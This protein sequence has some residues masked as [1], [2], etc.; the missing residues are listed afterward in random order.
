ALT[1]GRVDDR[2]NIAEFMVATDRSSGAIDLFD[3]SA[4]ASSRVSVAEP[5]PAAAA[6]T[7]LTG[8][9]RGPTG[10]PLPDVEL[11][12]L[13]DDR[14]VRTDSSG[15]YR[16]PVRTSAPTV[17]LA[18]AM[19]YAAAYHTVVPDRDSTTAWSP[20]LR[21]VQQ[22]AARLVKASGLPI[23]LASWR[24]DDFM[25]RRARGIGKFLLADEIW[26]STSIGDALN[27]VPGV[28]VRMGLAN[29]MRSVSVLRCNNGPYAGRGRVGVYVDG[30][31]RTSL[32]TLASASVRSDNIDPAAAILSEFVVADVIGIEIYRGI[33][34]IPAD[35]ANPAYC[36]VI[37]L[38]TR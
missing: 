6:M 28:N 20:R 3:V 10:A 32:P 33:T 37:S 8:V 31:E 19:G 5:A 29:A 18:R 7:W 2:A 25:A 16:L 24:Y 30:F 13:T 4:G 14:V 35:F 38:W 26:S 1:L 27:R 11:T 9:V 22:L 17:V 21:S 15:R 36:A 34:E 12:T 23:R